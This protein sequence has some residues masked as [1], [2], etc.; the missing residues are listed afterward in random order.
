M[1]RSLRIK[2]VSDVPP[3]P[4]Y[5]AGQVLD[6]IIEH[7]PFAQF[8]FL[9]LNQSNLDASIQ[10]AD[11]CRLEGTLLQGQSKLL[12]TI[13]MP[14][15][16]TILSMAV[17]VLT[18]IRL[19]FRWRKDPCDFLW[20]VLQGER[21]AI[22]YWIALSLCGKKAMLQ[23]WDPIEW[24]MTHR[25]YGAIPI[26]TG[27]WLVAKTE[28]KAWLN[29]VPSEA[30]RLSQT[31]RGLRSVKIDNFFSLSE[32]LPAMPPPLGTDETIQ[33]V[34]LGQLYA[35]KELTELTEHLIKAASEL[36]KRVVLHYFGNAKTDFNIPNLSLINHG[37][38][39]RA[40][41]VEKIS[42]L[43]IALL[44]YPM[45]EK[46]DTTSRRSFPSKSRVYAAAALPILA[47]AKES[48][49]PHTFFQKYYPDYYANVFS[50]N[51][52]A[53]FL[54]FAA[55]H[56]ESARTKR[57]LAATKLVKS[58]LSYEAEL[59]P[60]HEILQKTAVKSTSRRI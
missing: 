9:W 44:P 39:S 43:D 21:L 55:N 8:D 6:K 37:F 11:N 22:I 24:W 42:T 18:G 57:Y 36:Q 56:S 53:D 41:L 51:N 34:F 25:N 5:T 28:K 52:I 14:V 35:N 45:D 60:L 29:L 47:L 46:F 48:S 59:L 38:L 4:K 1:D 10:I 17:A 3:D 31:E 49:S 16:R 19:G 50:Q 58:H 20:L 30:W 7:T 12:R 13:K 32:I 54:K 15:L 23:Q 27:K 2:L 40:A 26:A 33:A